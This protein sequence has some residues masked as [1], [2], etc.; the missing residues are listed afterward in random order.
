MDQ[1]IRPGRVLLLMTLI[2]AIGC[3]APDER[4][5]DFAERATQ[6]QARQ[7]EQMARQSQQVAQQSREL[8]EAAHE[9][10]EQDAASRR[11]LL[12][13]QSELQA[14]FHEDRTSIDA[15]R[16]ELHV[17]RQAVA[18]AAI[19]E[20]VIAQ[21]VVVA[22]LILAALLPLLVTA[23]AIRR[24]PDPSTGEELLTSTLIEEL[25]VERLSLPPP[26]PPAMA[27]PP[28]PRLPGT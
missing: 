20:P 18:A 7:N 24:L 6:Q 16:Q 21:A 5:A 26:S 28:A 15:Q 12:A 4:L 17:E 19:R 27:T 8:A 2:V 1:M 3:E 14:Q 25:A 11:E 9:L 23:Y 13:A 10:V 22:G